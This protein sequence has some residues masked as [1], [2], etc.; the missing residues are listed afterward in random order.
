MEWDE[1]SPD[2]QNKY[3]LQAEMLIDKGYVKDQD[4]LALA[5][6]IYEKN[7]K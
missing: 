1:L 4:T 7:K 5:E 2:E 6:K 3:V